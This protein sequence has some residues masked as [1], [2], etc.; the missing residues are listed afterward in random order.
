MLTEAERVGV[1]DVFEM[2]N[3]KNTPER[4]F[5]IDFLFMSLKNILLLRSFYRGKLL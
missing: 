3:Y 4:S 1:R 5:K 2:R